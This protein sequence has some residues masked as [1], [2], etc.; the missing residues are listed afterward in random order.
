MGV[1]AQISKWLYQGNVFVF[2]FALVQHVVQF[3]LQWPLEQLF[4]AT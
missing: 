1:Y 3:C 4:H 2:I